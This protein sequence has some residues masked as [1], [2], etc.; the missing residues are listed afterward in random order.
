MSGAYIYRVEKQIPGTDQ[1][2]EVRKSL[3]RDYCEGWVEGIGSLYPSPPMRVVRVLR[4]GLGVAKV[5]KSTSGQS[6]IRM[7]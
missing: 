4:D 5:V 3:S 6:A 2:I 7:N 1:W